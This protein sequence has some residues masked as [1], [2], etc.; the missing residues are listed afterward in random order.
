MQCVLPVI[1]YHHTSINTLGG[2][3]AHGVDDKCRALFPRNDPTFIRQC[4]RRLRQCCGARRSKV[5]HVDCDVVVEV[6]PLPRQHVFQII[7]CR[8]VN[9][10]DAFQHRF[11]QRLAYILH[12]L[13]PEQINK[14]HNLLVLQ[15]AKEA[16]RPK[17]N[18]LRLSILKVDLKNVR[19]S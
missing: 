17:N 14:L 12:A 8:A 15:L 2:G 13:V 18:E 9:I 11:A 5:Q 6:S 19:D 3:E 10:C 4:S 16:I 7:R 1:Q